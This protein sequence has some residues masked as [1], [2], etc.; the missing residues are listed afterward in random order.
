MD[1]SGQ[2]YGRAFL[3][4]AGHELRITRRCLEEDLGQAFGSADD[5]P[6][7]EFADLVDRHQ[8]VRGLCGKRADD[9][10]SGDTVGPA[11]GAESLY[12]LRQGEHRGATWY[13]EETGVV[14]LCAASTFHRSGDPNDAFQEFQDLLAEGRIYPDEADDELL[15]IDRAE[16]FVAYAR[17]DLPQLLAAAQANPDTEQTMQIGPEPIS[18]LVSIVETLEE[19]YVTIS[20]SYGD[21][22]TIICA[23]L[24]QGRDFSEWDYRDRLPTRELELRERGELCYCILI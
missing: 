21:Y 16:N 7:Y 19:R 4:S 1:G 13:D 12:T 23:L 3:C 10:G 14:W 20:A 17:R 2:P 22:L 5:E 18:C 8:I 24:A 15:E 6:E 9:T 11:A